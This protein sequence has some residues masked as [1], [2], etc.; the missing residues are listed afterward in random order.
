MKIHNYLKK[1]QKQTPQK[2]K[3]FFCQETTKKFTSI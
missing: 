1:Q 2:T 3:L